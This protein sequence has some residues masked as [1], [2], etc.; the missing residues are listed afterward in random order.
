LFKL[1]KFDIF[2]HILLNKLYF[3]ECYAKT[4]ATVPDCDYN[5]TNTNRVFVSQT[6]KEAN[7]AITI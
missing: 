5:S 2:M 3:L 6:R 1:N 7:S 4:V